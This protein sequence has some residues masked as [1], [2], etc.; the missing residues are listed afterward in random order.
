MGLPE[1]VYNDDA[2]VS[3][4]VGGK[5]YGFWFCELSRVL[6]M[7]HG[8]ELAEDDIVGFLWMCHLPTNPDCTYDDFLSVFGLIPHH[9]QLGL[10]EY[11]KEKQIPQ[12]AGKVEASKATRFKLL[13]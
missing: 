6:P 10:A 11:I 3:V 5:S 13:R 2:Y 9:E 1:W 8:V 4:S 12:G 7:R